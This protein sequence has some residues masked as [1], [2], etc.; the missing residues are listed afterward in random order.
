MKNENGEGHMVYKGLTEE[1]AMRIEEIA[2]EVAS[3]HGVK[4]EFKTTDSEEK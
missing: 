4:V 1:E 2:K 3:K